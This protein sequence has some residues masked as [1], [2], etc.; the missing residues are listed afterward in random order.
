[1]RRSFVA[2][3]GRGQRRFP[4]RPQAPLAAAFFRWRSPTTHFPHP[5][6]N[7]NGTILLTSESRRTHSALIDPPMNTANELKRALIGQ[8]KPPTRRLVSSVSS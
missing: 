3:L 1:M 5:Q 8:H 6:G 2:L 4:H 7:L